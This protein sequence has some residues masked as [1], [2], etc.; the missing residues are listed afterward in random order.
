M[1]CASLC[2]CRQYSE[3]G[4]AS[5]SPVQR[6]ACSSQCSP[7]PPPPLSVERFYSPHLPLTVILNLLNLPFQ[8]AQSKDIFPH[9]CIVSEVAGVHFFM[10][11]YADD[12]WVHIMDLYKHMMVMDCMHKGDGAHFFCG[13]ARGKLSVQ[14]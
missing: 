12:K 1:D 11:Y 10:I 3:D 8:H 6:Q 7:L 9:L 13:E 2:P 14:Y 4:N 5:S